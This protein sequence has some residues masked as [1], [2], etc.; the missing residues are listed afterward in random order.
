MQKKDYS[1]EQLTRF[2]RHVNEVGG[3]EEKGDGKGE[4]TA[5]VE[6]DKEMEKR[7]KR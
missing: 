4:E 7:L 5:L 1:R 6:R 3:N 2:G